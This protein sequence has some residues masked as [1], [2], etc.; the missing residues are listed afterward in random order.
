MAGLHH[1]PEDAYLAGENTNFDQPAI[2]RPA[3]RISRRRD[4][5]HPELER[6]RE[7]SFQPNSKKHPSSYGP[8]FADL[9]L[10]YRANRL[11]HFHPQ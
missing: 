4:G 10:S 9:E 8:A 7:N 3:K 2:K 5:K 11:P 6:L 1:I